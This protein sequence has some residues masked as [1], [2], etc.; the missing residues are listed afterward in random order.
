MKKVLILTLCAILSVA[1]I[2]TSTFADGEKTQIDKIN[3]NISGF[4]VGN[5]VSD[6]TINS[7][8]PYQGDNSVK[9][10]SCDPKLQD[11]YKEV[12]GGT[13]TLGSDY[14]LQA[15]EYY[16][17]QYTCTN[18]FDDAQYFIDADT[19]FRIYSVS[20]SD[21]MHKDSSDWTKNSYQ[22]FKSVESIG[23]EF[24]SYVPVAGEGA[25]VLSIFLQEEYKLNNVLQGG[26][27]ECDLREEDNELTCGT[28]ETSDLA[29]TFEVGKSYTLILAYSANGNY[30]FT[31]KT[32][33]K[34][35]EGFKTRQIASTNRNLRLQIFYTV[36]EEEP[37]D[38]NNTAPESPKAP[39]SGTITPSAESVSA[40]MTID[41]AIAA[42]LVT[43]AMGLIRFKRQA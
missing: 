43:S 9:S 10:G 38:P 15:D 22:A 28:I 19:D 5:K 7:V 16:L 29:T 6:V 18:F 35:P 31:D 37:E 39:D 41:L 25:S 36:S 42:L 20:V 30:V 24:A 13:S 4:V 23:S 12:E 34:F 33:L 27:H 11:I 17:F 3:I 14:V 2:S 21:Y 8:V 40:E 26:W 1:F 32:E